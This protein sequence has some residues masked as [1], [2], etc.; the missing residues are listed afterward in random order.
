MLHS[1]ERRYRLVLSSCLLFDRILV[2]QEGASGEDEIGQYVFLRFQC[3][4]WQRTSIMK[5]NIAIFP[6]PIC[7]PI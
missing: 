3:R 5:N 6:P 4:H 2:V 1:N 7:R